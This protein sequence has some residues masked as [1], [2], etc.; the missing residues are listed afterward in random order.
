MKLGPLIFPA[1]CGG[2][3]FCGGLRAARAI[4][5]IDS[6]T[7]VELN[8]LILLINP[9]APK[10]AAHVYKYEYIIRLQ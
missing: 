2:G 5:D 9:S 7:P 8:R 6:V 1:L 4:C 3:W 10:G